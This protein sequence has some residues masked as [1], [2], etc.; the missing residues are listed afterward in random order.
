MI[1]F[2]DLEY[3]SERQLVE[4]VF[5]CV[6]EIEFLHIFALLLCKV[7]AIRIDVLSD[8]KLVNFVDEEKSGLMLT[9]EENGQEV[10]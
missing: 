4:S 3:V 5:K 10:E 7:R 2:S 6:F 8:I 9:E 1:C